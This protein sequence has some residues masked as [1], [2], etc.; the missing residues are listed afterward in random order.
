MPGAPEDTVGVGLQVTLPDGSKS[1]LLCFAAQSDYT[2]LKTSKPLGNVYECS[3]TRAWRQL[4]SVENDNV[5]VVFS[6]EDFF[7]AFFVMARNREISLLDL[8][9]TGVYALSETLVFNEGGK[10][11]EFSCSGV[12]N[13]LGVYP[14]HVVVNGTVFPLNHGLAKVDPMKGVC[15]LEFSDLPFYLK[16][17]DE[18]R[19]SIEL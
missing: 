12:L 3:S 14:S 1:I 6:E 11:V 10:Y 2:S 18:I 15:T 9:V 7:P 16:A 19:L 8:N 17:F 5:M 13:A 4:S